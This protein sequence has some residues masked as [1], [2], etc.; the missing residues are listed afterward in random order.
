LLVP[1]DES[2]HSLL[3]PNLPSA[4]LIHLPHVLNRLDADR[5]TQFTPPLLPPSATLLFPGYLGCGKKIP[6][7]LLSVWEI[8]I[9]TEFISVPLSHPF[10]RFFPVLNPHFSNSCFNPALR[11]RF[12]LHRSASFL[13]IN[14]FLHLVGYQ[15][16]TTSPFY[17]PSV[18]DGLSM[19]NLLFGARTLLKNQ[20]GPRS[21]FGPL[22]QLEMN[23]QYAPFCPSFGTLDRI[24]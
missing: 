20:T 18:S 9:F 14:F 22:P 10:E 5:L 19:S 17:T 21:F 24:L 7:H 13:P 2:P 6:L 4:V 16:E 1:L 8:D 15:G 3:D 23:I 12:H 11:G